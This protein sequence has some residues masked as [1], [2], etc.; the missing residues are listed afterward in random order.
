MNR[1]LCGCIFAVTIF[2]WIPSSYG[3]CM[4]A[5]LLEFKTCSDDLKKHFP[6]TTSNTEKEIEMMCS[7]NSKVLKLLS[8]CMKKLTG[9]EEFRQYTKY[10]GIDLNHVIDEIPILCKGK[11]DLISGGSC[12]NKLP[13]VQ[14]IIQPLLKKV[15]SMM[16]KVINKE[17][18]EDEYYEEY[19]PLLKKTL[20]ETAAS[21]KCPEKAEKVV[22]EYFNDVMSKDCQ[23]V[24]FSVKTVSNGYFI[25]LLILIVLSLIG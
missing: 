18:L 25:S 20:D 15:A 3:K 12:I 7:P 4:Q 5:A 19:C 6:N 10:N 1:I 23:R 22:K 14:N 16:V 11:T 13:D 24:N 9:C 2:L 8:D 21:Y 17:I